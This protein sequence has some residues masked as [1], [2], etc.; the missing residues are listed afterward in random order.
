MGKQSFR[1]EAHEETCGLLLNGIDGP[2]QTEPR[3][4]NLRVPRPPF[5]SRPPC[6]SQ[7]APT[8]ARQPQAQN[9]SLGSGPFPLAPTV[10]PAFPRTLLLAL[11]GH[12]SF[13]CPQLCFAH[14]S[15]LSSLTLPLISCGVL[16]FA[17]GSSRLA[18]AS[19]ISS[20]RDGQA[21]GP[22]ALPSSAQHSPSRAVPFP[23]A[24][25]TPHPAYSDH[26]FPLPTRHGT[27]SQT[28]V[29]GILAPGGSLC[30]HLLWAGRNT[31]P[32]LPPS[33]VSPFLF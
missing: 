4:Q 23:S 22:P 6:S 15:L 21:S 30:C 33:F 13:P 26:S 20:S 9:G 19:L 16:V 3:V 24:A 10:L 29:E 18:E 31:L 12:P 25:R 28:Q 27:S 17:S 8:P 1:C 32:P 11:L 2:T 5:L 7:Q 14:T